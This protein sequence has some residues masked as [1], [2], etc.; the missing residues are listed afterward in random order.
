MALPSKAI[1]NA[2]EQ[3]LPLCLSLILDTLFWSQCYLIVDLA[4]TIR[5]TLSCTE[6][7]PIRPIIRVTPRQPPGAYTYTYT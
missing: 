1:A 2:N 6:H 7:H 4:P 5:Y 3:K